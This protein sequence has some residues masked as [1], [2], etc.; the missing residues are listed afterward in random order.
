MAGSPDRKAFFDSVR[1]SLFAGRL[2]P[3]HVEGMN[4]LLDACAGLPR[5]QTAYVLATAYHESAHTMMP[6]REGLCRTDE[7]SIRAVTRMFEAGRIRTN[8]AAPDPETGQSYFGRGYP[9]LTW[10]GNYAKA[11]Q[12]LGIDLVNNPGRALEPAVSAA[13]LVRGMKEGWFTGKKL[14]DYISER[15]QICDYRNARRI[16]NGLDK[17]AMIAGYARDFEKALMA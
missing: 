8:Y 2:K 7:G 14:A 5:A 4:R 16:I 10:R 6:V 11:G 1:E 9:Q 13:I 3:D 12:A 17:A 15:T